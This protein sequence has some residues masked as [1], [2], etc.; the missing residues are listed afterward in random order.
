MGPD[1]QYSTLRWYHRLRYG[2]PPVLGEVIHEVSSPAYLHA[3]DKAPDPRCL[4]STFRVLP[5]LIPS[6]MMKSL[7]SP[8]RHTSSVV[9][10]QFMMSFLCDLS[11]LRHDQ[12]AF[13]CPTYI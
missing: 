11:T 2:V 6:H 1:P 8:R 5:V 7:I 10:N 13:S 4:H 3:M 9:L 12:S